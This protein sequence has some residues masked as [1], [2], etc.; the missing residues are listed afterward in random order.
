MVELG[1][2]SAGVDLPMSDTIP[3][4]GREWLAFSSKVKYEAKQR[5]GGRCEACGE[6]SNALEVHHR[7]P[8]CVGGSDHLD[9]AVV[10]CGHRRND[11]KQSCHEWWD[12]H[13]LNTGEIY[14]G[15][16]PSVIVSER[17]HLVKDRRRF[18]DFIHQEAI[19]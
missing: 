10:L 3:L 4:S 15:V 7:I 16:E 19:G 11:G 12:A 5:A 17:P 18:A 8:Q 14:P 9:N 6:Q 1:V 2:L 13:T